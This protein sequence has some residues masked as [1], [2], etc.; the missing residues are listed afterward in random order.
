MPSLYTA[1]LKPFV[2]NGTDIQFLIDQV[3]FRPLFDAAGNAIFNWDGTGAIYD[4]YGNQIWNGA[5]LTADQAKIQYG[6]SYQVV[7]DLAGLRDP[8]GLNNNLTLIHNGW[9]AA[10][11]NFL[12]LASADYTGYVTSPTTTSASYAIT[13][14]GTTTTAGDGSHIIINNIVD[15]SPR[16][17]SLLTTTGGVV[18]DTWAN[19]AG[20]PGAASHAQNEIFYDAN[21]VA[22][23]LNW[24]VLDNVNSG[25]GQ[26]DPQARFA[27]S[28]GLDDHFIG[29]LNP[30]VSPSNGFFVLFG[31]FFDHGLD[32]IG[33]GAQGKTI[34]ITLAANDPLYGML[35]PDGQPT[36]S[37]TISRA[38][39]QS[40]DANGPEYIDHTSPEIDQSQTY[41]SHQQLTDLLRTWVRDPVDGTFKAGI[42][43]FD[44]HT[45]ATAWKKADGSMTTAT[46]P[47]LNELRAHVVATGRSALTWEDVLDL[48]NRDSAGHLTTGNSGSPLILDSNPRFDEAHLSAATGFNDANHNGVQDVGET[49]YV[50]FNDTNLNGVQNAG[51]L[52][53]VQAVENAITT[54]HDYVGSA[55][56]VT[57]TGRTGDTFNWVGTAG[58]RVLTLHLDSPLPAGPSTIP[59]GDYT[60]ANALML[61]VNFG[62]F[63]IMNTPAGISAA[64][65]AN[66]HNAVSEIL[67]AS[68]GDHYIAGDGRVNENFGLT[69]IHHIFHEE[70]NFQ[71]QNLMD[72]IHKDAVVSG[73]LTRLHDLQVMM[74]PVVA[75]SLGAGVQVVG[76]GASAHYENAAGDYVTKA[77]TITWDLEKMFQATK[78]IVEMEY[79]HAAVDQYARNVTPNIQEFV[80]YSPDKNPGITLEYAQ[81]AFRFGHSTLRETID[82]IDPTH[83]LTGKI[84]GYALRDAFLNPDQYADLGP[85][86]I[87]LGMS[88]QQMNE[89]DEFV[90]PA[91]NQGL[92]GLPLDLA[93]INIAR[94]RDLGIP[95]LNDFR[96]AIGL[97][98]YTSWTNFGTNMQHP[99]SLA[100]FIAAYSFTNDTAGLA[101]AQAILGVLDGTIAVG[102]TAAMGY[103]VV[104]AQQFLDSDQGFNHIDTW[105]G[106]LAEVH[107]PGGLLGETFDL[108]FVT[109]IES[110]MD[111]DRFYYLYR[112]AGQQFAD[113][114]GGGQ[115]KDIVERNTG[116]TH[117]NG[118]IFGYAD[119]YYDFSAN[120]EVLIGAGETNTTSNNHKYGNVVDQN[121]N[122]VTTG[123]AANELGAVNGVGALLRHPG[124]GIYTNNGSTDALDGT[125]INVGGVNYIRDTRLIDTGQ[126]TG[127]ALLNGGTALDGEPNSGANSSEVIVGTSYNDL[128]YA[129]NG[130]DTVYGEGGDDIIYGGYGID[131]LYGGTGSDTIFGGDN[132]DLIDG[133]SGDDFIYAESSGSD[134]NGA[135]QVI[136]GSGNDFI[137][138]GTGIDKL[139][140]GTGDDIIHGDGDT[141]PFTHGGDGND[142]VY[143]DSGG[144]IL[145]GDNGDDLVVGGADQDQMFGGNG[146]DIIRPGDPTGALTIGTDEVLGG[147]GVSDV[148][149]DGTI[150]FDIIDFSDNT[151]RVN[152]VTFDLSAQV[153][154]AVVVNGTPT[155]VQSFQIEGVIG[156]VSNDTLTGGSTHVDV[157]GN[158]VVDN[159]WLIGG[160]GSDR[161]VSGG[162]N[163]LVVGGSVRLDKLIGKYTAAQ[164]DVNGNAVLVGGNPVMTGLAS[165]YD[166][167]NNNDGL[168]TAQQIMDARYDGASHRVGYA[169]QLDGTGYIDLVNTE[170]GLTGTPDEIQ[171]HFTEMLR[172]DQFKDTMLGDGGTD[173]TTDTVVFTGKHNEYSIIALDINGQLVANPWL[174]AN[175]ANI[176]AVRVTDNGFAS[177][178]PLLAR[179][180]TDGS[181]LIIGVEKFEFADGLLDIHDVFGYPPE[182]DL[183]RSFITSNYQDQFNG[184]SYTNSTGSIPWATPW[185]EARDG[186]NSSTT[187]QIRAV[188]NGGNSTLQF[189]DISSSVTTIDTGAMISRVVDLS[190]ATGTVTLSYSFVENS[191]DANERVAVRFSADGSEANF[192]TVQTLNNN[193]NTGSFSTA[194]TGPFSA[195][196]TIRFVVY[197]T[198]NNSGGGDTVRIDNVNVAYQTLLAD[199]STSYA[200]TF[201]EAKNTTPTN[202]GSGPV[203]I[204]LNTGITDVNDTTMQSAKIVLTN[205]KFADALTVNGNLPFQ[206]NGVDRIAATIDNSVA[207]QITLNLTGEATLANYQSAINQI[208]FANTSNTPD[209]ANRSIE[210]TVFDGMHNSNIAVTTVTVVDVADGVPVMTIGSPVVVTEG[211]VPAMTFTVS[212]ST[213]S[214]V[215]V[216]VNY[217][218]A[219]G[220]AIA[221]SDF[222]AT[223][224]TLTIP[225]GSLT[226]TISVPIL[227]DTV[228]EL[229]EAFTLNLTGMVGATNATLGNI[230]S[231]TGTILNDDPMPTVS[232]NNVSLTE[233]DTGTSPLTFTVSLSNP[234]VQTV[235]V[236]YATNPGTATAAD[237]AAATGTLTFAPG[238]T[239]KT[240]TVNV[241]GD[242]LHENNEAFTVALSAP[243]NA[244]LSVSNATG[245]GT[246]IDN[247]AVPTLSIATPAAV[248]EGATAN[249]VFTVSLSAPSGLPV[250]FNYATADGTATA[251]SDYTATTGSITIPAGSTS[252]TISVPVLNDNIHELTEAFTVNLS[253]ISGATGV[254]TTATGT[255]NDDD[256][257]TLGSLTLLPAVQEDGSRVI[258]LTELLAGLSNNGNP[259]LA[260]T[261]LTIA[262]GSGTLTANG[263]DTWTYTPA[264]N[265]DTAATFTYTAADISGQWTGTAA[266]DIAPVNDAP[267]VANALSNVSSAEDTAILF[268]I[269]ANT[270]SDIDNTTLALSA[271]MGDGSPLP[272]W[273]N[274][275]S[276][277]GTFSGMPPLNYNGSTSV[278]VTATDA[279]NLS[280]SSTFALD[281]T[282]VNDAP[283]VGLAVSLTLVNDNQ[284]ANDNL[285]VGASDVDAGDALHVNT[286]SV[287]ATLGTVVGTTAAA[288]ATAAGFANVAAYEAA[289]TTAVRASITSATGAINL[290]ANSFAGFNALEP[291]QSLSIGLAYNIADIAGATVA[292]T[293]SLVVT[294][295]L[296]NIMGTNAAETL[297]GTPWGDEITGLDGNDTLNGMAGVDKLIGGLGDDQYVVDN[298]N[299]IVIENAGE[300]YD[301]VYATSS[302]YTL[303]A[304]VENL[305]HLG[306]SAFTGVGNSGVNVI[307]GNSGNDVLNGLGGADTMVGGLGDDQFVVDDQNDAVVENAGEG[308]DVVYATSSA[309]T[310]SS[311]IETLVNIGTGSFVGTGNAQNNVIFGGIGADILNGAGGMDTIVAG[312]GDDT[313]R[314][315]A[316]D[317]G[318]VIIDGG[319]G[320]D[321]YE[322]NGS[323]AAE[324]F[325][326]YASNALPGT[327]TFLDPASTILVAKETWDGSAWVGLTAIAEMRNV[328]ELKVLTSGNAIIGPTTLG[329]GTNSTLTGGGAGDIIRVIGDFT[330]TGLAYNTITIDGSTGGTTVDISALKSDHRIVF[331]AGGS[332]SV[333]GDLRPQDVVNGI[334][335]VAA[336]TA[337]T[338]VFPSLQ[339]EQTLFSTDDLD[340]LLDTAS[341]GNG[342]TANVHSQFDAF[343]MFD[344]Q[345]IDNLD[346]GIKLFH[347]DYFDRDYLVQ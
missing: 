245:T 310:L 291:G 238:E 342:M 289:L 136:G 128:V 331:D 1:A 267:V 325:T 122:V 40:V 191:F 301:I 204:A 273:L 268:S 241:T 99:S 309:Y 317:L 64:T 299:D 319:N 199:G 46:L 62:N 131:R 276:A 271:T 114:V 230:A 32:F 89:V 141:D 39:V 19:H 220:T 35:G 157:N 72:A 290:N 105:L 272:A 173:G 101:K 248:T 2:I 51:E 171:K 180:P 110:L 104:T 140:G 81:A 70:H 333:I 7:T 298:V 247:D 22:S 324:R 330:G 203:A 9:G 149:P 254:T 163:D 259:A 250:T 214:G 182:L 130:D 34:K 293:A 194:L 255:I 83:G 15:G 196:S 24:G 169:D 137:S 5:G 329:A 146:D 82:T 90:T 265:D 170:L 45:L 179:L 165:T 219:N 234:S 37:I 318:R 292:Q 156:S 106:G 338:L 217:A 127:A 123:A 229:T 216:T 159:N 334:A 275:S 321:T 236:N 190:A 177:P 282:P 66:V 183:Q 98:R 115:L 139:A 343:P 198:N 73:D 27:N 185:A 210:V 257:P 260:I 94:G 339:H 327:L 335:A 264:A 59:A 206:L 323:S 111:G 224:G 129:E 76:A 108:V 237:F 100:N 322:L 256:A 306:A 145:Y 38:N 207:G 225:A 227:N 95:T 78:L 132:P 164:Y 68:V 181:D 201:T 304:N 302:A 213:A 212:L 148:N 288:L 155:Q 86:S 316:A 172:T 117:L 251:G 226:G 222:T 20:D 135:D 56:Y 121:G 44:G 153:N 337:D 21:G 202:A 195:N 263:N 270:F 280:A 345:A 52:T 242:V 166:H 162:G 77:G 143:G 281:I 274:F 144:D 84:M 112:L 266:L 160:S 43:M 305:I 14:G 294:G 88:H 151:Q 285:L 239:T 29:G 231:A 3:S 218:T 168:T 284:T 36:T 17:I 186:A 57:A 243:S 326:I 240:V 102:S 347:F 296:E 16:T 8:S 116:L 341:V 287:V 315:F 197:G 80:G 174:P 307:F 28:A 55:E 92:L 147:D 150:G 161:F 97:A 261:G 158:D 26:V 228:F 244:T 13:L 215:P 42:E 346:H 71:V 209:T 142:A 192:V 187:G 63:N 278:K 133:G 320:T 211:A 87:L 328:E 65:A 67:M 189:S 308:N 253:A 176:Y 279:G 249:L 313:I 297:V 58:N 235:T 119:K 23:V 50:G 60:G 332:G 303:S 233:G 134:I 277:T 300:G 193:S 184:T 4:G 286:T 85:A 91:L 69:S 200:T 258:T 75:G 208:R 41:G 311:N 154:P 103:T 113:E 79:Q 118:N 93:A 126:D 30:G 336:P 314:Q 344:Y 138:G 246:I 109:Q 48:R 188:T 167:N 10:D 124:L 152:G 31:Q 96:D 295:I 107:Q 120:R 262:S 53:Q 49:S 61:W 252:A 6:T 74:A 269:P 54:L 125:V 33:K 283:T 205:A 221:G 175:F 340:L 11:Q 18:F 25:E 312:N 223:S 12:R 178:D 232:I 47:T